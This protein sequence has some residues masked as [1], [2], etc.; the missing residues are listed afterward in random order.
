MRLGRLAL[1]LACMALLAAGCG[2]DDGGTD[3][4]ED[5]K[6]GVT[7][8]YPADFDEIEDVDFKRSLGGDAVAQGGVG[9]D[10][11][12]AILVTRYKL[13]IKVGP[14][15]LDT[16]AK[17]I[18]ALIEQV[19]PGA[20]GKRTEVAGVPAFEYTDVPAPGVEGATSRLNFLID[21][22]DEYLLNCQSRGDEADELAKACRQ[23][24]RTLKLLR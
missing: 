1:L 17:E 21:G 5:Q 7:F 8:E 23:A 15:E 12:N 3:T 16:A 22:R 9:L 18:D 11:S 2:D 10:E 20:K 14:E 24:L 6:L 4:F 19:V 13:N